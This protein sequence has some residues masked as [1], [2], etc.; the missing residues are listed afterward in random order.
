MVLPSFG[1]KGGGHQPPPS[2]LGGDGWWTEVDGSHLDPLM[3][4]RL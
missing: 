3:V 4:E 2:P 1:E